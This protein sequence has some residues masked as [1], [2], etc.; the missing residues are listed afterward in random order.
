MSRVLLPYMDR[1][2]REVAG[3]RKSGGLLSFALSYGP[4]A[5]VPNAVRDPLFELLRSRFIAFARNDAGA[6][7][8][9]YHGRNS[10]DGF[11]T[12]PR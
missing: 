1:R 6:L 5:V 11:V 9:H 3:D 8:G 4:R 10:V 2:S 7:G 12:R